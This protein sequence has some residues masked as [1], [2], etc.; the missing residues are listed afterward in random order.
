M[1]GAVLAGAFAVFTTAWPCGFVSL[2]GMSDAL[3]LALPFVVVLSL[4]LLVAWAT[5]SDRALVL[6]CVLVLAAM[7]VGAYVISGFRGW[8]GI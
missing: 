4:G 1:A 7:L 5:R 6:L 3:I 2:H 8:D